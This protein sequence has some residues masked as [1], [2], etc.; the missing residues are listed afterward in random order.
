MM[1]T[2]RSRVLVVWHDAH[3]HTEWCDI[4]DIGDEP[5]V[6]NTVGWLLPDRIMW[7]WLSRSLMMTALT[8]CFLFPWGWFNL[9]PF[10]EGLSSPGLRLHLLVVAQNSFSR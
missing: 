8:V 7:W 3:S 9:L 2:E 6:V 5:Y 1:M 4:T 10:C